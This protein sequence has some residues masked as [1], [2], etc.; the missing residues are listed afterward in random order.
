MV[1]LLRDREMR[2]LLKLLQVGDMACVAPGR[3]KSSFSA[4][5]HDCSGRSCTGWL[6]EIWHMASV[7]SFLPQPAWEALQVDQTGKS[8]L[9]LCHQCRGIL[10]GSSGDVVDHLDSSVHHLPLQSGDVS[11]D[12]LFGD[13]MSL[14]TS[15]PLN[16]QLFKCLN[17]ISQ[18]SC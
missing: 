6:L 3:R 16:L 13:C 10:R 5:A 1:Y 11:I 18:L 14:A 12:S 17:L 9:H 8:I 4:K 15:I 7:V 2:R